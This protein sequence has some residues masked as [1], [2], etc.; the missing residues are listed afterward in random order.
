MAQG[1]LYTISAPSGAGKTSLVAALLENAGQ[2][3]CVSVSHTTRKQR[4]G[5]EHGVNYHFVSRDTFN[6]LKNQERFLEWAEVFGN[7]YGTSRDWVTEQLNQGLD[8]ILEI[9]WQGAEQIRA[10]MPGVRSIFI[11]PPD[12]EALRDR[13]QKRGQDDQATI[14]T[15]MQQAR[16]EISHYGAADYLVINDDFATALTDLQAIFRCV[17][18]EKDRQLQNHPRLLAQLLETT[19]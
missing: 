18:L 11:L 7:F 17:R 4:P 3:I 10:K 1:T 12:L 15:R 13:L 14:D 9:D 6:E 19:R 16:E 5:E 8:V 2:Q